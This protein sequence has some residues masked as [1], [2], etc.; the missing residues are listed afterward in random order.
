M[1][2]LTSPATAELIR[3]AATLPPVARVPQAAV[4]ADRCSPAVTV[5]DGLDRTWGGLA[6][7]PAEAPAPGP[8]SAGTFAHVF[9]KAPGHWSFMCECC[10]DINGYESWRA[11]YGS[12]RL[13]LSFHAEEQ[14]AVQPT[15]AIPVQRGAAA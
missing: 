7:L 14:A 6:A 15:L 13:H 4:R 9:C 10:P 11:A 3:A 8:L 12:A 2:M 1:N 5:A